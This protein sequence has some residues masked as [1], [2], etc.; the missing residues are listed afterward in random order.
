MTFILPDCRKR[1]FMVCDQLN[2][3]LPILLSYV[4]SY[5][6]MYRRGRVES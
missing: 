3:Y 5:E 1:A 6:V 2:L 4:I